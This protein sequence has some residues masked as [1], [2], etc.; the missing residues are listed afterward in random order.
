[1]GSDGAPGYGSAVICW[2]GGV[3]PL[4]DLES[5]RRTGVVEDCD[6]V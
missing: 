3:G 4:E 2:L 6:Y 1:V 5:L